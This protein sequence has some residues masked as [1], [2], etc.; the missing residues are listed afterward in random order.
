M[1]QEST[2]LSLASYIAPDPR[3]STIDDLGQQHRH[4]FT[5]ALFNVLSTE[6]PET[7]FV[8]IFDGAPLS[9]SV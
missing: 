5:R 8:R 9:Q 6:A 4:A 2:E 3:K 7:T 1:T